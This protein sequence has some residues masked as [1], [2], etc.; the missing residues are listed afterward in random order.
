MGPET[1]IE[2][3]IVGES[4]FI[5][6]CT[7]ESTGTGPGFFWGSNNLHRTGSGPVSIVR[8]GETGTGD[9][10]RSRWTHLWYFVLLFFTS[11]VEF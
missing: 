4:D 8:T 2:T 3:R 9:R 11:G 6:F 1:K 7:G 5:V 10:D